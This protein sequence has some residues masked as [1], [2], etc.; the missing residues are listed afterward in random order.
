MLD[1]DNEMLKKIVL[2]DRYAFETLVNTY[3]TTLYQFALK[4]VAHGPSAEELVQD[5]LVYIWE[6]RATLKLEKSLKSYLFAAVKYTCLNHLRKKHNQHFSLELAEQRQ[7]AVAPT[8][9]L[10]TAELE[11]LIESAI[12]QLPEKCRMIFHLSR[13]ADMTYQ[14]IASELGISPRT[15]ETQI[16]IALQRIRAYLKKHWDFIMIVML[17]NFF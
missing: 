11:K 3:Y 6:K 12:A 9:P 17:S 4:Y 1:D 14:E 8:H 10:E 16:M 7:P 5:V 15:V 2:G 13:N